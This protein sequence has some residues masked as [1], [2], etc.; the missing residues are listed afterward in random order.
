MSHQLKIIAD[1]KALSLLAAVDV[2]TG[3]RVNSIPSATLKLSVPDRPLSSFSQ[4]DV[5]A[6]LAHCQVGKIL[7]LELTD[8]GRK[9]VLF[10][11]LITRK[12]VKI[13]NKQLLLTL[14]VKHRLQLM[15]DTQHS[16]LFKSSSEKAIL[17]TLLN[18][19]GIKARFERI[20]ALDQKHEQMVQFRCSDWHFLLCRLAATGVWLLPTIEGVQLVQPD[21]LKSNSVH[22]LK[23]RGD[24][25]KDIVVKDAYWQFD[26]HLNP[27]SLEVSGWDI[28]KQQVLSGGRHGSVAV[29]KAALS[30]DR[31]ASL[32][33]ESWDIRYSS[34]LTTQESGY[35][36]QG[37]LLNQRISG[38]TG[39]FL[40]KGDGRYQL[41]DN[42][43]LTGFGSQLDGT[44]SITAVRHRFNRRI[45]WETTVNIGLQQEYLPV[46][47]DAPEL[48]I[49]TV[50]KY[51]QDS[52][53][54]N[55]IPIILPVLNRPNEFL[56]ARLGKPYA[57]HESGFCFYP[58]P[59][60]EV[61]VGFFENDPRYP[62]ILGA[63]HNPKNKAPLEPSQDNQEKVLVVKKGENQQQLFINGKEKIIQI[64]AG[65]NQITLQQDKDIALTTKK[66]L[67]LKAQTMNA[68]ME[69]SVAISGKNSVEIKGAKINLTQ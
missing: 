38:V 1:G 17:N 28:S 58:E 66:E 15:V 60:D 25:K 35:L 22:T 65:E 42:I 10:N 49:A 5:Q 13:K 54:L 44:A 68:T 21:A 2:D 31:L 47:P 11:G 27:A 45:G 24:E 50:A 52:A 37:L 34:P 41:G 46:L 8:G 43:Q 18:Q 3:Y 40:L 9:S 63:M 29:G 4:T 26:N 32:N 20:A 16:Q 67:T 48:H 6:E 64:N 53:A 7:R 14:V 23:S 36:A 56:W 39:E 61:I 55:R 59:G 30:P 12:T 69:K 57:S 51:Q 62:V 19:A 33:K